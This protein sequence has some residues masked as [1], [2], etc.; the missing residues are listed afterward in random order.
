MVLMGSVLIPRLLRSWRKSPKIIKL[1][2]TRKSD[3]GINT[4]AVQFAH[5]LATDE[6]SKEMTQMKSELGLVLSMLL[7]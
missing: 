1:R 4:F 6:I 2:S 7:G 5:N 3:T